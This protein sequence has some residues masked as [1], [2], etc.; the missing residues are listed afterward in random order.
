MRDNSLGDM[1]TNFA[2]ITKDIN[3]TNKTQRER[4]NRQ[5]KTLSNLRKEIR[6]SQIDS[7]TD[8]RRI[9]RNRDNIKK[10]RKAKKKNKIEKGNQKL[11]K[12]I[13]NQQRTTW[14]PQHMICNG[15][16]TKDIELWKIEVH[17]NLS[18]KFAEKPGHEEEKRRRMKQMEQQRKSTHADGEHGPDLHLFDQLDARASMPD[19]K[20]MDNNRMVSEHVK[21]LTFE[22]CRQINKQINRLYKGKDQDH[23]EQW[24]TTPYT[25][26][27]KTREAETAEEYRWIANTDVFNQWYNRTWREQFR[28]GKNNVTNFWLGVSTKAMARN[29]SPT[30]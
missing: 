17:R 30:P 12:L 3:Y 14:Q 15:I 19:N 21:N 28:H 6:R 26:L 22:S 20:A 16:R 11:M 23:P 2:N 9:V 4:E 27:P 1:Q 24:N 13:R 29:R 5:D 10:L 25:G 18:D 8:G 7:Q